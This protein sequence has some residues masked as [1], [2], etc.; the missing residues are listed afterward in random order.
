MQVR[1]VM[2][3]NPVSCRSQDLI[4]DAAKAMGREDVGSIPVVDGERLVGVLTDRD[5]VLR[6]VAEGRDPQSTPVG[7]VASSDV[8][9]V[10]PNEELDRALQLLAERRVRRLPVV[11]DDKLV[12]ILAQ[13]DIARQG[14]DSTTGQVVEQISED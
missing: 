6:V 3:S 14:D 11:E 5:I 7:E 10:S 12:G 1:E 13:A 4:A 2:T 9:T 8:A